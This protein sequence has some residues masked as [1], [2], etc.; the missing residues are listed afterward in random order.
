MTRAA[1]FRIDVE[2]NDLLM[3]SIERWVPAEGK[4]LTLRSPVFPPHRERLHDPGPIASPEKRKR[5]VNGIYWTALGWLFLYV[6]AV[7]VVS[8]TCAADDV[9]SA[10]HGTLT[11]VDSTTKTI[12]V[13]MADGTEHSIHV[14]DQ[15]TVHDASTSALHAKDSWHGLKEGTEVV[16]HYTRE[17]S[18][19][20][21]LEIDKIGKAGLKSSVGTIE[22]IDRGGKKLVVASSDGVESTYRLTDHAA[23]DGGRDIGA[24]VEKGSKVTVYYTKDAGEKIAHFFEKE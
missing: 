11:K 10:V 4:G 17:G 16:V 19:D 24:G 1:K 18:E 8:A 5:G 12:V 15:T 20:T 7:L 21:A 3:N 13:K 6:L 14:V 22:D 9:V 23:K 2:T